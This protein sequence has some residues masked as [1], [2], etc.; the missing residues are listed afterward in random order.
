M[1]RAAGHSVPLAMRTM[2]CKRRRHPQAFGSDS[3]PIRAPA[4]GRASRHA[5]STPIS[6][7]GVAER[8]ARHALMHAQHAPQPPFVCNQ[9]LSHHASDPA[10]AGGFKFGGQAR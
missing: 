9:A 5:G 1:S 10:S 7:A 8:E 2:H 3:M 4:G 6:Y